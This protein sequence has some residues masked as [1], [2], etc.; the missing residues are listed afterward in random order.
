MQWELVVA[1]VIAIPLILFP[2][3]FIWYLNIGGIAAAVRETR[4]R[5]TTRRKTTKL[6]EERLLQERE[7]EEA[8]TTA[9]KKH[10]WHE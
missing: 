1:L 3:V 5:L 2:V 6:I 7:Y 8:L 4:W 10:P 9:L